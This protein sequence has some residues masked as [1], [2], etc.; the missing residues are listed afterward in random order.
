MCPKKYM[1]VLYN[2]LIEISYK[3]HFYCHSYKDSY[4]EKFQVMMI[5]LFL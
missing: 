4:K 1:Y 2:L 5:D 3:K